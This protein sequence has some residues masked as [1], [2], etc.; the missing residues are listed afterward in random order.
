MNYVLILGANSD[1]AKALMHQFAQKKFNLFLCGRD[2]IECQKTA[3]D[4]QIRYGINT[5][6]FFYHAGKDDFLHLWNSL[7]YRP[8]GVVIAYG[9]LTD[10]ILAQANIS[11]ATELLKTNFLLPALECEI[12]ANEFEK[13]SQGFIIGISSVA[14]DR[15]RASNYLYGSAKAGFSAYLSGLRNRLNKHSVHVMTIK[16]GFVLTK[17]TQGM[18]L[19]KILSATPEQ[20]AQDIIKGLES[21]KDIVYT[22]SFWRLIMLIIKHLPEKIFKKLSL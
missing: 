9:F 12:I 3:N 20:I 18:N 5:Q 15:G 2:L 17:M 7:P 4:L 10:Q 8:T 21:K 16:P 13:R 6:S 19:P 22:P 1:I 11:L 14:G